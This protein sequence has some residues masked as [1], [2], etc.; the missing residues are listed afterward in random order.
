MLIVNFIA[1]I[2]IMLLTIGIVGG[3]LYAAFKWYGNS[4][5]SKIDFKKP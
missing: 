3:S 5:S 1:A 4:E 2:L